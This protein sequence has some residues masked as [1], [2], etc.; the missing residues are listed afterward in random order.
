MRSMFALAAA[1]VPLP[2]LG[3]QAAPSHSLSARDDACTMTTN[4]ASGLFALSTGDEGLPGCPKYTLQGASCAPGMG[5]RI[6][7]PIQGFLDA[8]ADRNARQYYA[9]YRCRDGF[10]TFIG[11]QDGSCSFSDNYPN[12]ITAEYLSSHKYL[13]IPTYAGKGEESCCGYYNHVD[14][15]PATCTKPGDYTE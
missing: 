10:W 15:T 13:R 6:A 9:L 12:G 14:K 7:T 1:A 4:H 3:I 8:P 2:Q 11:A 5:G